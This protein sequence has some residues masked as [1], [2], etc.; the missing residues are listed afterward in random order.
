MGGG[1]IQGRHGR[2][3]RVEQSKHVP[4]QPVA[5][6]R[7]Q[8]RDVGPVVGGQFGHIRGPTGPVADRIEE[9]LDP[10]EPAIGVVAQP[11]LDDLRVDGGAGVADGLDVELPEL[12][13]ATRLR[14][15]VA[16][17]R[18]DLVDLHRLRPGLHAVLDVGADD[19][20]GRLRAERPRL[21]LLRA[22]GDPEQL[23]LDDVGDLAHAALEDRR[24]LEHGGLDAAVA[25]AR[26]E[27]RGQPLEPGPAGR[28]GRQQVARAPRGLEGRHRDGV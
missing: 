11:E 12:P 1:G 16:E 19:A 8:L 9:Y 7:W 25:V 3:L 6:D 17:H 27:V 21:R 14:A 15:V 22:R 23:L 28:L 4:F 13:V 20:R 2:V 5:L 24:L 10:V 26:G 18:A